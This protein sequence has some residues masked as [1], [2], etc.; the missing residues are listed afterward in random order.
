MVRE[1]SDVSRLDESGPPE[2]VS[3]VYRPTISLATYCVRCWCRI[4]HYWSAKST[5]NIRGI[6]SAATYCCP[7]TRRTVFRAS[8]ELL[9]RSTLDSN[10]RSTL[11]RRSQ[12]HER[13]RLQSVMYIA[14]LAV[15]RASCRAAER[16]M[17]RRFRCIGLS[18]SS[19]RFIPGKLSG[20]EAI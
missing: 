5:W 10:F 18:L 8:S 19:D 15:V 3:V 20:N 1:F 16:H 14:S 13:R 4:Y 2:T 6:T 11:S 7:L 12:F 17:R 9:Q